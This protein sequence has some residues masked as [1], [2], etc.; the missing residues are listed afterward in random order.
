M[1]QEE[2]GWCGV[3][4]VQM[5]LDAV[6]VTVSQSEIAKDI[7]LEWWGSP[8]QLV[9]AYLSRYFKAVNYKH[10]STIHDVSFHLNKGNIVIVNFWD[11]FL[12]GEEGDGHYSV[13]AE[14]KKGIITLIDPS[15][16]RD[17]IWA[18]PTKIFKHA[19][20]DTIE[21]QNKLYVEGWILWIDPN[22]KVNNYV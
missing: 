12:D 7:Y 10:N 5:A 1:F 20:F 18:V 2:E 17:G 14:C 3:A 15:L 4:C 19:W 21:T 16:E 8:Q 6:G 13:V 11:D 9:L 22:T